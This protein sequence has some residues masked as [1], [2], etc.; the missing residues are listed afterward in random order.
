MDPLSQAAFGAAAAQACARKKHYALAITMGALAGLAPDLD[1]LIQSNTNPLMGIEYHRHFTHSLFF[2]PIGALIVA[3]GLWTLTH[4]WQKLF[5][6]KERHIPP[7]KR[8]FYF[9]LI[10]Y[11]THGL[12]DS[13]TSYGTVLLW[14]LTDVRV[15]WDWISII[16]PLVTL[17][18]M[19]GIW[20]SFRTKASTPLIV[21]CSFVAAY[22][23]FLFMWHGRTVNIYEA[24]LR[25]ANVTAEGLRV[26]PLLFKPLNYRAVF[27]ENGEIVIA[28]IETKLDG[29]VEIFPA[30]R[31]P[32]V[33]AADFLRNEPRLSK[34]IKTYDWFTDGYMGVF[35]SEPLILGDYRYG[36]FDTPLT[37]IWAIEV[38]TKNY[39][40]KPISMR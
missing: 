39:T 32:H 15:A 29:T 22:I 2:I 35:A 34:A 10:G 24:H 16:D 26:M 33:P 27:R 6:I 5:K 20:L 19:A 25:D 9:C 31:V 28:N 8:M 1:V 13:L 7:F 11:A 21:G 40:V 3:T 37:P 30:G 17:P 36:R 4:L 38:D 23:S 18:L 12:V 14:P